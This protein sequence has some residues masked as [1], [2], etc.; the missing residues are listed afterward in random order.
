MSAILL[1]FNWMP[2]IEWH[3]SF[4]DNINNNLLPCLSAA[5]AINATT[6]NLNLQNQEEKNERQFQESNFCCYLIEN[7]K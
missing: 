3:L 4:I 1:L 7:L 6:I 5:S 2:L